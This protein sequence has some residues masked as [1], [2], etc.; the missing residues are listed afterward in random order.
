[1]SPGA[2]VLASGSLQSEGINFM[3]ALRF[4]QMYSMGAV[5]LN[6]R[7][8]YCLHLQEQKVSQEAASN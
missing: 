1:M 4:P 3:L 8:T 7:R 5:K 2:I 6:F